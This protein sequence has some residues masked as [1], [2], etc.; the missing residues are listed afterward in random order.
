MSSGTPHVGPP[1][2]GEALRVRGD[3]EVEATLPVHRSDEAL[4]ENATAEAEAGNGVENQS[5]SDVAACAEDAENAPAAVSKPRGRKNMFIDEDAPEPEITVKQAVIATLLAIIVIIDDEWIWIPGGMYAV[6]YWFYKR[7]ERFTLETMKVSPIHMGCGLISS[8]AGMFL[9]PALATATAPLIG[10]SMTALARSMMFSPGGMVS[11][12]MWSMRFGIFTKLL[13]D[14]I[15]YTHRDEATM[16]Y[17]A[18]S[19]ATAA[20]VSEFSARMLTAPV[21]KIIDQCRKDPM[22]SAARVVRDMVKRNG[23]LSFWEGMAPLRIEVPHMTVMIGTWSA[24]RTTMIDY[25]PRWEEQSPASR[26]MTRL[27]LDMLAGAAG[28]SLSYFLTHKWRLNYEEGRASEAFFTKTGKKQR[29]PLVTNHSNVPL[30]ECLALRAPQAAFI[31]G[32]YGALMSFAEPDLPELGLRGWGENEV[33]TE[34]AYGGRQK[35]DARPRDSFWEFIGARMSRVPNY[36][37]PKGG[38]SEGRYK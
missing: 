5:T 9:T 17:R 28:C 37:K 36:D 11:P 22:H 19:I 34:T 20:A 13:Q 24:L 18:S 29:C 38:D 4:R 8:S 30:K 33:E 2:E 32:T 15:V 25:I 1:K 21:A 23:Y 26:A 12:V 16:K 27:P 14:Q 31:F 35:H 3:G 10:H 6:A 7:V